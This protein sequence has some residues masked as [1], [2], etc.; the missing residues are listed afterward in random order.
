MP[1]AIRTMTPMIAEMAKMMGIIMKYVM[2]IG[3]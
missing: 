1:T 3:R 2:M